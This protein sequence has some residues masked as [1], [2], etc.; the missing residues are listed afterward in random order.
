MASTTAPTP[1]AFG[2]VD[3]RASQSSSG[4]ARSPTTEG[5]WPGQRRSPDARAPLPRSSRLRVT[6]S[7]SAAASPLAGRWVAAGDVNGFLGLCLDNVTQLV[8]LSGLLIG[9]FKF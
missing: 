8:V 9:V 6:P 1:L 7:R 2:W 4:T 5:L 3:G